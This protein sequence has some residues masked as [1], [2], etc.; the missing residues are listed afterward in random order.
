M[1]LIIILAGKWSQNLV[2]RIISN[3]GNHLV[4]QIVSYHGNHLVTQIVSNHGNRAGSWT[5]VVA[6][7]VAIYPREEY[8]GQETGSAEQFY[9]GE[10][11]RGEVLYGNTET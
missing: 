10:G 1:Y 4:T 3:H 6:G 5:K 9:Q 2:T 7:M 8:N 11:C